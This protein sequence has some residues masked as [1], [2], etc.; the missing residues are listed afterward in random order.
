M[1]RTAYDSNR[2]IK[3]IWFVAIFA[4]ALI[5]TA[6]IPLIAQAREHLLIVGSSTVA[7]MTSKAAEEFGRTTGFRAPT[8]EKTGTGGGFKDFC[9]GIGYEYP[10]FV[11]ASR[12]IKASEIARCHEHG[13]TQ[14]GE[15]TIGMDG[16]ALTVSKAGPDYDLTSN[17]IFLAM[18]KEVPANGTFI[19]NPYNKWSDIRPELPNTDIAIY[20]PP[21]TSGTYDVI[22]ER[23]LHQ[24]CQQTNEYL[25]LSEDE[26]SS[27]PCYHVRR[28]GPY[29]FTKEDENLTIS[30][31]IENPNNLGFIGYSYKKENEDKLKPATINGVSP[32]FDTIFDGSYFLARPIFVYAKPQHL[33]LVNGMKEFML[34]LTG[35]QA[36]N[37]LDGYLLGKGLIPL[38]PEDRENVRQ[39]IESQ[40]FLIQ[41][42]NIADN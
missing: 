37:E 7:P 39:S 6:S 34:A 32:T 29:I 16:I 14:I 11:N 41:D 17:D 31:L 8:V 12:P 42:S 19:A 27:P 35:E 26:Q 38:S 15:I 22:V 4:L 33:M 3:L 21:T 24:Q 20:G 40:Q 2:P 9:G 5:F 36:V 23:L 30:K 18:A 10:D 13:V 28:D 1:N 25:T